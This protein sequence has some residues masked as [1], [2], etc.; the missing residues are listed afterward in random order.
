MILAGFFE[1]PAVVGILIGIPTT[2]VG[3]LV[4]RRGKKADDVATEKGTIGAVYAGFDKIIENLQEDN[5]DLRSRLE[6][7]ETLEG[8]VRT[9]L[10]RVARLERYIRAE[11]LNVPKNGEF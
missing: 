11:G 9:L 1:N 7:V 2:V 6:R 5:A 10:D 4:Y 3:V 8:T